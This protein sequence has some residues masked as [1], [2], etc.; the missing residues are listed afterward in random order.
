MIFK[1]QKFINSVKTPYEL[2]NLFMVFSQLR[3]IKIIVKLDIIIV[4]LK[5]I[6]K[7]VIKPNFK[8]TKLINNLINV[9]KLLLLVA[10]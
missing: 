4:I 10:I 1:L 2:H 8:L 6:I 7:V 5:H 9:I 3:T